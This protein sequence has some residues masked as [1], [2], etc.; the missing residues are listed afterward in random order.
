VRRP[1]FIRLVVALCALCAT[2]RAG[3]LPDDRADALYHRYEGG[4]IQIQG[5]SI[6]LRKKLGDSVSLSYNYYVD[7]ITG[8]VDTVSGASVDAVS[9]ASEYQEHRTQHSVGADLLHG[10]TTYSGGYIS[11][12][13]ND[14]DAKTGYLSVSQD[15]FGDLTTISF[16]YTVGKDIVGER[17]NPAFAEDPAHR[18]TRRNWQVGLSQVLTRNLLLGA[19]FE[20]S[21][22]EGF[23]NNPY[24]KVRYKDQG[25]ARGYGTELERYPHTRTGNAGAVQLKYYLPWRAALD[26][27]YRF[28]SDTWGITAHTGRLAYTQPAFRRWT[29]EGRARYYTQT[30][31]DF[32]SD[33]FDRPN[34]FNFLA[35]DREL[36]TFTNLSLGATAT[37][38]FPVS[39]VSFLQKGT[40][41]LSWDRLHISYDDYRDLRTI[42]V[43]PGTEPLYTLD[44][45]VLQFFISVWY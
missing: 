4:G 9:G 7:S 24:R 3:V 17:G 21:E 1:V 22:S 40:L 44:A 12:K 5:P 30:R 20:T 35:R 16:G 6:L 19:N 43:T 33:L 39:R 34:Q 36:A 8:H 10:K 14:Y 28:Y 31:A 32:Y 45:N 23:L 27:G 18:V 25:E 41:N 2:G 26:G 29:F 13:E 37:W 42:A 38:E 15:M 11:S